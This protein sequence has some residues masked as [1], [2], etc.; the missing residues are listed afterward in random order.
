MAKYKVN[1]KFREIGGEGTKDLHTLEEFA[2]THAILEIITVG[3]DM[4]NIVS[5]VSYQD[6]DIVRMYMVKHLYLEFADFNTERQLQAYKNMS[7]RVRR[8]IGAYSNK[9]DTANW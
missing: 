2:Q 5:V 1:G 7:D 9:Y 6:D 3:H 8:E 4:H